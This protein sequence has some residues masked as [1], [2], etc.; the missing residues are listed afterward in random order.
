MKTRK[1]V[2]CFCLL[3]VSLL[4]ILTFSPVL[5]QDESPGEAKIELE[6][7]YPKLE[8]TAPGASFEFEVELKYSG[9]EACV[10]DLE[11][12][13]PVGWVV[14]ITPSYPKDKRI[15]AIRLEP[16]PEKIRV[17]A[18]PPP[19]PIPDPGEYK[20]TLEV[21]SA[22]IKGNIELK[23]VV[24]ATYF[25]ALVPTE[26]LYSTSATAGKDNYFS[27]DIQNLGSGAI[28]NIKFSSN[29]PK[30]WA[31]DFSPDKVDSLSAGSYQTIDVNIK[32][33][34][35]AIAGDYQITL[36]ASGTQT[37]ESIDIRVTVETPTVWGWVG[38]GIIL[39]VIAGV[40]VIF[41][42][43]SRR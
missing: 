35:K 11:A 29:K 33:S 6:A 34:S 1:I 8:D 24:A 4:F 14:Y 32:P 13:G 5:A 17:V 26:E 7:A 39:A 42:R 21:S 28:E 31:I 30:G 9:D 27:I 22:E 41:M 37:S 38:V 19:W 2:C 15:S 3:L 20:I 10:F 43:F 16:Y 23:A 40:T 18:I 36:R 12:T 25:L